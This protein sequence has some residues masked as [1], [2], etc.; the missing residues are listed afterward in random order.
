ML[1]APDRAPILLPVEAE[2][3]VKAE[4]PADQADAMRWFAAE[5][6]VLIA[7]AAR[8][9]DAW[10]W[11]LAWTLDTFLYRQGPW[12]DL[13]TVWQAAL[14]TV[15][16]L[17]PRAYAHS[18][19][20]RAYT[21]LDRGDDA[22]RHYQRALAHYRRAG[23]RDG[24]AATHHEL[25]ILFERQGRMPDALAQ[26]KRALD[27]AETRSGGMLNT[28]GFFRAQLGDFA[29]ALRDCTEALALYQDAGSIDEV[30]AVWDSLGF[31]RHGL[32]EYDEA[33][34]CYD[35]ALELYREVGDRYWV[36]DTLIHLGDTHEVRGRTAE[37][38]TAWREALGILEE[39][40][41]S[42]AAGVRERLAHR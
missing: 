14:S 20:A 34:A 16:G 9:A 28:V 19:L 10:P 27:L 31:I 42:H 22:D 24:Q 12:H 15:S 41:H 38:T 26:A 30:A 32:G 35:R 17:R 25:A 37:A 5:R 23:D 33:V 2:T 11:Q 4:P 21:L 39:L 6:P 7:L 3:D 13:L 18:R 1:L 29:G 8:A 36:A 40:G